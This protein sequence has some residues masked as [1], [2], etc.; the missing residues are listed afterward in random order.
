[1]A[2]YTN[3]GPAFPFPHVIA[4]ANS[5]YFKPGAPGMTLEDWFAGMA[6][7]ALLSRAPH[8]PANYDPPPRVAAVQAYSYAEAMI[9]AKGY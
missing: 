5:P 3:G 8:S 9:E 2:E 6:L 7:Q 1:M 4:D